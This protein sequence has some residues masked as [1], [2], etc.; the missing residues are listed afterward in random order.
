MIYSMEVAPPTISCVHLQQSKQNKNIKDQSSSPPQT[1]GSFKT[2]LRSLSV[3]YQS[4]FID[5]G[6]S[7]LSQFIV[8]ST[9]AVR[10]ECDKGNCANRGPLSPVIRYQAGNA[11]FPGNDIQNN[12]TIPMCCL[13]SVHRGKAS[14]DRPSRVCIQSPTTPSHLHTVRVPLRCVVAKSLF[15]GSLHHPSFFLFLFFLQLRFSPSSPQ[16]RF[17][18]K[19]AIKSLWKFMSIVAAIWREKKTKQLSISF[20]FITPESATP[21]SGKFAPTVTNVNTIIICDCSICVCSN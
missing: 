4:I 15:R 20:T 17:S 18:S 2:P 11:K 16:N 7:L 10:S 5:I 1:S 14:C 13:C 3:H 6:M 9:H 12:E 21:T 19:I 8:A